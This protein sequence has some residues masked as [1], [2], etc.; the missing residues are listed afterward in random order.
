VNQLAIS[1]PE[2]LFVLLGCWLASRPA[3]LAQQALLALL[4]LGS[5]GLGWAGLSMLSPQMASSSPIGA[6]GRQLLMYLFGATAVL[7]GLLLLSS[8]RRVLARLGWQIET[9]EHLLGVWLFVV[10]FCTNLA[11]LLAAS[12]YALALITWGARPTPL[13]T[14]LLRDLGYLLVALLGAGLALRRDPAATWQ[15]LGLD[16][17]I[18]SW[19]ALA[20]TLLASSGLVLLAVLGALALQRIWPQ[21]LQGVA[22]PLSRGLPATDGSVMQLLGVA[23]CLGLSAGLSQEVLLRGLIQPVF[24]LVPT[25]LLFA[26]MHSQFGPGPLLVLVFLLGLVCGYLRRSYGTGAAILAHVLCVTALILLWQWLPLA[27]GLV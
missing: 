1:V 15:R 26:V 4:A 5:I 3:R 7:S 10:M 25:A 11:L 8:T 23:V 9:S 24:G 20:A 12:S 27:T 22:F 18:C 16:R 13:L 14:E 6:G 17:R 19:K 21:A 2:V